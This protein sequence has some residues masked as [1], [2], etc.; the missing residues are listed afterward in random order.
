[1]WITL[2]GVAVNALGNYTLMFGHFGF[3]RME[4]RGAGISTTIVNSVMCLLIMLYTL[5]HRRYRRYHLLGRFWRPD[6]VKFREIWRVGGPIGFMLMTEVGLFAAAALLMGLLGTDELAAHAIALQCA[7]IAFMIPMGL[8]Q[9]TTVRVGMAFGQQNRLAIHKAGWVSLLLGTGF[10]CITC[11]LFWLIPEQLIGLF[12]DPSQETNRQP[13]RL[14]IAF[15]GVAA[16][17]QL[18]DGAQVVAAAAL[19]GLNDT[20]IPMFV[21]LIGYWGCGFPV[22][23]YCGFVLGLGGEGVWYGLAAG[24][25]CVAVILCTRFALRERLVLKS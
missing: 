15:L 7:A 21:A 20:K 12:L 10:M 14:A 3:P 9:A 19:R 11:L 16:L 1:L 13:F 25:A 23:Y 4:L 8:S 24:L 2:V 17:F 5:R 18:A 22:A 6:W